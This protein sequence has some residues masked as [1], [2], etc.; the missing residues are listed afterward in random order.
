M[1]QEVVE[2][3]CQGG[4]AR[5]LAKQQRVG[6]MLAGADTPAANAAK[7]ASGAKVVKAK[8]TPATTLAD[9]KF[10]WGDVTREREAAA[11]KATEA[12]CARW[13]AVF[14]SP[15]S[16]GRERTAAEFLN[17]LGWSAEKIINMLAN[18]PTDTELTRRRAASK[19]A[20]AQAVWDRAIKATNPEDSPQ[21][22][23]DKP[24]AAQSIWDRAIAKTFSN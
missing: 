16:R 21:R 14:A 17:S 18:V 24:G 5:W 23:S 10:T 7:R 1:P 19:V 6:G 20:T 8:V 2:S 12:E 15:V 22:K 9:R 13:A 11:R 4:L 3:R